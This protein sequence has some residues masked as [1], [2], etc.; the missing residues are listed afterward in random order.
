[1]AV[2]TTVNNAIGINQEI[3]VAIPQTAGIVTFGGAFTANNSLNGVT[4]GIAAFGASTG[5]ASYGIN[6][7]AAGTGTNYGVYA[8]ADSGTSNYAIYSPSG[9]VLINDLNDSLSDFR[10]RGLVQDDLLFTDAS[11]DSVGI[12][13]ATPTAHLHIGAGAATAGDAPLKLTT[14]PLLTTAEQG[15]FEFVAPDLYFTTATS[16]GRHR[17][18]LVKS[19]W[20]TINQS[21]LNTITP[22][23]LTGMT[24]DLAANGVYQLDVYLNIIGVSGV[25]ARIAMIYSGTINNIGTVSTLVNGTTNLAY[26][27]TNAA[28]WDA[29][30]FVA[31]GATDA[32]FRLTGT[33]E[34]GQAGT[35][36]VQ[37]AQGA[38]SNVN[39][40]FFT[41]GGYIKASQLD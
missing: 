37:A 28:A 10:V 27:S 26:N 2:G 21:R 36:S 32:V 41:R 11:A 31:T 4:Y 17:I 19:N 24:V 30:E 7:R 39:T 13:Q 18:D 35:L 23:T 20:I 40:I 14:G 33:F 29:T 25:G 9:A 22:T 8:Q 16:N 6:A 3:S 15:A 38:I 12:R 34:V 5:N 1:L